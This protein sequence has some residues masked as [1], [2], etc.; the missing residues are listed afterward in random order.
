MSYPVKS[1]DK[2]E[3]KTDSIYESNLSKQKESVLEVKVSSTIDFKIEISIEKTIKEE[4]P[5]KNNSPVYKVSDKLPIIEHQFRPTSNESKDFITP[6]LF[7]GLVIISIP[8]L[9]N[10]L[11]LSKAN[12]KGAQVL[13]I[14]FVG[15]IGL[16]YLWWT[17]LR[18]VQAFI[19][20][21]ILTV[22]N[23]TYM[24]KIK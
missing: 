20:L 2:F 18:I 4:K 1:V 13:L 5:E 23:V 8:I 9:M 7:S 17:C 21:I 24:K 6:I 16:F 22:L 19:G 11:N 3:R 12:L 15:L 14:L 10:L